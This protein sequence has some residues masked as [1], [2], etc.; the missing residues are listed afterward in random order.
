M[1][2][3]AL[4][5]WAGSLLV[6]VVAVHAAPSLMGCG[7]RWQLH[8]MCVVEPVARV[9]LQQR[10]FCVGLVADFTAQQVVAAGIFRV[11]NEHGVADGC[12][13]LS[14]VAQLLPQIDFP[15]LHGIGLPFKQPGIVSK[16]IIL[17]N[18]PLAGVTFLLG[19]EAD[20]IACKL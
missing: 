11:C 2:L 6:A 20:S 4:V 12:H 15:Q 8:A 18:V 7:C 13:F 14:F 17:R 10:L 9:T 1:P 5:A 19:E 16:C 3:A